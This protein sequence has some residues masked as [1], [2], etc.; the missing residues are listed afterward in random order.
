MSQKNQKLI[1]EFLHEKFLTQEPFTRDEVRSAVS[2]LA[3]STLNTYWSKW[4]Q[5]FLV[6]L[7]GKRFRVAEAF[8]PYSTWEK[9]SWI[10]TQNRRT[11]RDYTEYTYDNVMIY[12]FLMPLSNEEHL[13]STLDALF[14]KDAVLARLKSIGYENLKKYLS[15]Q[16]TA[17]P[18]QILERAGQLVADRFSG[19]SIIHVSGRFRAAALS[20]LAD[21]V[22]LQEKGRHYL[23]DE[24]TAVVRFIFQCGEPK[25]QKV[26]KLQY[27]F[28][29]PEVVRLSEDDADMQ[30]YRSINW[31]FRALFV[32]NIL[33]VVAGEDE[34]WMVESGV[35][36]RL[37]RWVVER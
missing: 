21:A 37:H 18:D 12:D 24:T 36:N 28:F 4:I 15:I 34:I 3:P 7:S 8:R 31:L 30:V 17:S 6:N 14:Y 16:D 10:C 5:N 19:Y 25:R 22:K 29:D 11:Y 26:G 1:F 32:E 35:R 2:G 9:F 13:R 27:D 33:Q 20:T 23:I